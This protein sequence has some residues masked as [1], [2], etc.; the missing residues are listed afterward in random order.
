MKILRILFGVV[1]PVLALGSAAVAAEQKRP[2]IIVAARS[3]PL[4]ER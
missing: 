4:E 3:G 2:R 1:V